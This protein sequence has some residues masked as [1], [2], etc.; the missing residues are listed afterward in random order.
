MSPDPSKTVGLQLYDQGAGIPATLPKQ[1]YFPRL[2]RKFDP[3]GSDAGLIAAA[4]EYGRTST[5]QKGRG[6]GLAEMTDWIESSKSGFLK[7]LSGA[8]EVTYRPGRK[9]TRR[10]YNAPFCGTL[11]QWELTLAD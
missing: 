10:N 1:T 4:M 5:G 11:V 2:L 8:G 3:E 7:I 9:I 6:K